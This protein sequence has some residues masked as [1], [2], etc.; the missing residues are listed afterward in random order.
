V[1][2]WII[3]K[4]D[5]KGHDRQQFNCGVEVLNAYL[6]TRANQEQKKRLNVTYVAVSIEGGTP[7]SITGYYTLSNSSISLFVVNPDYKKGIPS[8]YDIPSVKI[9]RLAV[10][11]SQQSMGLGAFLLKDAFNRII[12][13]SSLSAVRGI[14][15][16]A[17]TKEVTEFYK[18]YGFIQL[19]DKNNSLYLP[20][21][22]AIKALQ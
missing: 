18:K 8:T 22:S 3:E 16:V 12:D 4:L 19:E 1:S 2:N 14:E 7:K 20:I 11:V 21:E 15:V 5:P 10:D 13:I 17:K 9:G 6:K